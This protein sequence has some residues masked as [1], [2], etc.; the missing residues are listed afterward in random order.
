M[1][2]FLFWN[3]NRKALG[4][5]IVKLCKDYDVDVLVLAEAEEVPEVSLQKSLAENT[6][7]TYISPYNDFS[8]RLKFFFRYSLQSI[9]RIEDFYG[10][11]IREISFPIGQSILLAAV[12]L[13]SKLYAKN[14]EQ[15]AQVRELEFFWNTFDQV[16]LRPSLLSSFSNENLIVISKI[17]NSELI[18]SDR[19]NQDF[20]DH[21]PILLE[22]EEQG[23]V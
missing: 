22:L 1:T 6:G 5:Q 8:D 4:Q 11:S 23:V 12:H 3:I 15:E 19:V 18:K 14:I 13:S 21:L 9:S 10:L 2:T 7:C 20:S 17:G 16:L